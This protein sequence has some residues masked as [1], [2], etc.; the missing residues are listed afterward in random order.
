M[1]AEWKWVGP[2]GNGGDCWKV[3]GTTVVS[4]ARWA[5][6][7]ERDEGRDSRK[8]RSRRERL[9]WEQLQYYYTREN[10]AVSRATEVVD[11]FTEEM[12]TIYNRDAHRVTPVHNAYLNA[13]LARTETLASIVDSNHRSVPVEDYE[14]DKSMPYTS[15]LNR[16][17]Y[18]STYSSYR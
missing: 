12:Q 13:N 3:G 9:E 10:N 18:G 7:V 6:V 17:T 14:A 5:E 15:R 4:P 1:D 8:V 11:R 2:E 16:D